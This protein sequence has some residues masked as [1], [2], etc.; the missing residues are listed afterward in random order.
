MK[1]IANIIVSV[2]ETWMLFYFYNS[3]F[4]KIKV[5]KKL[6]I[7]IYAVNG[8]FCFI[9]SLYTQNPV[10]RFGCFLIFILLPLF[11]YSEKFSFK[12]IIVIIYIATIGLTELLVKSL[13]IGY[14]GDM[15]TLYNANKYH[16]FLGVLFSKTLAFVLIYLFIFILKLQ[17]RKLPVYLYGF[18]FLIPTSSVIIFY[19]LQHI[20]YTV[21]TKTIYFGYTVITF[22]LL[23]FNLIFSF[24]F[25]KLVK[26]VCYGP[27]LNMENEL[28][29]K[30][31][32]I[33]KI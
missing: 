13:L 8:L 23:L 10:Q 3:F 5:S 33:I 25:P 7:F 26:S 19:Y 16:Y 15:I 4:K 22:I 6:L 21:N 14:S 20:V 2:A 32:D 18:L 28:C 1:I 27:D 9:Y 11:F 12:L 30:S 29:K 24:Y 17:E 31:K